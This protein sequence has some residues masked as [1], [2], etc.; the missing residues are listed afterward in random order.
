MSNEE[1]NDLLLN[2]RPLDEEVPSQPTNQ[3][4]CFN[5]STIKITKNRPSFFSHYD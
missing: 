1:R 3:G 5:F 4:K 2:E